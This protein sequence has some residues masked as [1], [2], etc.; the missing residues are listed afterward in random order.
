M[1]KRRAHPRAR[2]RRNGAHPSP[3]RFLAAVRQWDADMVAAMVKERPEFATLAD[4]SGRTPLHLVAAVDSRRARRPVSSSV[5]TARA[6]LA[7][8]AQVNAVQPLADG[9]ETFPA[10]PLWHAIARGMNRPLTRFLLRAGADANW[11]FWTVV[12][13]D[14]LATARLL[15][16]HGADVNLRFHGETPLLYATRLRRTRM[17]RWLLS[18]GAEVDLPDDAGRTPLYHAV[19]RR[20]PVADISILLSHGADVARPAIDG[21]SPLSIAGA[22]L[23]T[24]LCA[25]AHTRT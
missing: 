25:H 10:R 16:S 11:C 6:L 23:A 24:T 14:D 13:S 1:K 5:A 15:V 17:M 2:P 7:A 19:R 21:S 22:R 8:G 3:T 9:D 18:R 20:H 12:W 4:R